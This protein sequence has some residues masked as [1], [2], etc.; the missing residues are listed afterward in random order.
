[1]TSGYGSR[2]HREHEDQR[3]YPLLHHFRVNLAAFI[4]YPRP[5]PVGQG[6]NFT[7]PGGLF[8]PGSVSASELPKLDG[9][10]LLLVEPKHATFTWDPANMY[11]VVH[12]ALLAAG[13]G[14]QAAAGGR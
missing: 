9:T 2:E 4:S 10:S 11:P 13:E 7:Y 5:C 14:G 3:A 12:D 6:F 1:M 8:M